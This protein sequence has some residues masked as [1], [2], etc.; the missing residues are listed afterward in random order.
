MCYGLND[1]PSA[2][3][4][5]LELW[6]SWRSCAVSPWLWSY[7]RYH[8]S[9]V[10]WLC[11]GHR[12]RRNPDALTPCLFH[13]LP[14]SGCPLMPSVN[15]AQ[16]RRLHLLQNPWSSHGRSFWVIIIFV[17]YNVLGD[18]FCMSKAVRHACINA[19]R[20]SWNRA[21]FEFPPPL[22]FN[23]NTLHSAGY[24]SCQKCPLVL[25]INCWHQFS[26]HGV[27]SKWAVQQHK[28]MNSSQQFEWRFE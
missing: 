24:T 11:P 3:F 26:T 9:Y 20:S 12:Q 1:H 14:E 4:C 18:I 19:Y 8:C 15:K 28:Q 27:V 25:F 6:I 13:S 17:F 22:F 21:N 10:L 23:C 16:M 5:R 7:C 2:L